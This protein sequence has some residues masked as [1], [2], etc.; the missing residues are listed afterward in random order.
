MGRSLGAKHKL[1]R[2]AGEKLCDNAKC[3]VVR[4]SYP[5]GVHG[6]KGQRRI[7]SFGTEMLEKQ[8]AKRT[9]GLLE[10]QFHNYFERAVQRVGDTGVFLGQMLEMRFDN[11]VYR[12]GLAATRAQARQLVNH[13]HFLVNTKRVTIP[14]YRLRVGDVISWKERAKERSEYR[15]QMKKGDREAPA[16]LSL[17]TEQNTGTI[18]AL[19]TADDFPKNLN[20]KLII[21]HYSR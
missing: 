1:C 2:R 10:R 20:F 5:P 15:E 4:R 3:P 7:T 14:S 6:P 19:P 16:W 13:G 21:E 18:V 9:Y 17:N 11:A 12:L 8:K